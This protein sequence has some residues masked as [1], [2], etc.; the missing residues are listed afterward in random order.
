MA[1]KQVGLFFLFDSCLQNDR[2]IEVKGPP[3]LLRDEG[4]GVLLALGPASGEQGRGVRSTRWGALPCPPCFTRFPPA[5]EGCW[6]VRAAGLA[7]GGG[8]G[9]Q[10]VHAKWRTTQTL[11]RVFTPHV[12]GKFLV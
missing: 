11:L 3:P 7:R 4:S 12:Q 6:A 5:Q 8:S 1:Y 10:H 2:A 9:V